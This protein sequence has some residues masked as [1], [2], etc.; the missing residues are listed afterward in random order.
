M[1]SSATGN[2]VLLPPPVAA[3]AALLRLRTYLPPYRLVRQ[4]WPQGFVLTRSPADAATD[5]SCAGQSASPGPPSSLSVSV[6]FSVTVS[7]TRSLS[8]PPSLLSL[9]L[10]H[11]LSRSLALLSL[12][13]SL[14]L[15]RSLPPFQATGE[16]GRSLPRAEDGRPGGRQ[17]PVT[18]ASPRGSPRTAS[19]QRG[20]APHGG[21]FVTG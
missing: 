8:P 5:S 16:D 14:S 2:Q 4:V 1:R 3:D 12:S 10:A 11:S 13:L 18:S 7:L 20:E 19:S 15:S 17:A 9:A 21:V 6:S